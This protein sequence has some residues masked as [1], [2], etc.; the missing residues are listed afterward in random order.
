MKTDCSGMRLLCLFCIRIVQRGSKLRTHPRS[1]I[2][3]ELEPLLH[4]M[5][6]PLSVNYILLNR[7]PTL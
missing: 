4:T 2:W 3:H 5:Y 6:L 7:Q 1:S